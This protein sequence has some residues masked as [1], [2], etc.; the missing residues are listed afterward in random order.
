MLSGRKKGPPP[1]LPNCK[2]SSPLLSNK[3]R[4][5][6]PRCGILKSR[7]RQGKSTPFRRGG[8]GGNAPLH[9]FS[10]GSFRRPLFFLLLLP[11]QFLH[12]VH[13]PPPPPPCLEINRCEGRCRKSLN[14]ARGQRKTT[15][16]R[17]SMS[18][19]HQSFTIFP[20][21]Q[22]RNSLTS[23]SRL[24]SAPLLLPHPFHEIRGN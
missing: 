24:P 17:P 22:N 14:V 3:G 21:S 15:T 19:A 13:P 16:P 2:P 20:P 7:L 9:Y 23:P 18:D 6:I 10:G 4:P 12:G 8:Q 1:S 5:T 11:L